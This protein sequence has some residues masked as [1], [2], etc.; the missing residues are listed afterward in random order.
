[1]MAQEEARHIDMLSEQ[2]KAYQRRGAFDSACFSGK[3]GGKIA[4]EVFT[5]ALS[6]KIDA[7]SFEA[8][9]MS[10]EEA[11]LRLYRDRALKSRDKTEKA[12]YQGLTEWEALHLEILSK[13][14]QEP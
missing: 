1:M 6:Q 9:A 8:A 10:M 5:R 7:A 12:V 13:I 2:F 4:S 11:T 14:D 3:S